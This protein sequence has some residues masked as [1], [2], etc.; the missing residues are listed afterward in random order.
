MVE[1]RRHWMR[2]NNR[3]EGYDKSLLAAQDLGTKNANKTTSAKLYR[4]GSYMRECGMDTGVFVT[5]LCV[6]YEDTAKRED[7]G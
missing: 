2:T 6:E 3:K 4:K 7:D 5:G 1:Y